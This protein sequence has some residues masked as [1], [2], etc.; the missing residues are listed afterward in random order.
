M[1]IG[2]LPCYNTISRKALQKNQEKYMK[3]IAF[4][5]AGSFGFT[6]ALVRDLLTFPAFAD[7]HIALMDINE[8][9][10]DFSNRA[11]QKIIKAGTA[12]NTKPSAPTAVRTSYLTRIC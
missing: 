2:Y 12:H 11:V 5:G 3:K 8:E 6:R 1:E 10:L 4:I 9:R 7:A